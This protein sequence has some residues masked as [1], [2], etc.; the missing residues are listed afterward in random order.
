MNKLLIYSTIFAALGLTA[1][2]ADEDLP[3]QGGTY[4]VHVSVNVDR[5]DVSTDSR[6]IMTE[7]DR[8]GLG[9]GWSASDQLVVTD[10]DGNKV[11]VLSANGIKD[12]DSYGT[13][14]GDLLLWNE[15][16]QTLNF[17][18]L[19]TEGDV[20]AP[21]T[22]PIN[23]SLAEQDGKNEFG[24][25][26]VMTGSIDVNVIG[27][28]LPSFSFAMKHQ[29]TFA[30]F[31]LEMPAGVTLNGE[32]ITIS[33]ANVSNA[34]N[35]NPAT[36]VATG[37]NGDIT[38]KGTNG[39]FYLTMVPGENVELSFAVTVADK[40]Y[41]GTLPAA[42]IKRGSYLNRQGAGIPVKMSAENT[43]VELDGTIFGYNWASANLRSYMACS[44]TDVNYMATFSY[45]PGVSLDDQG[46]GDLKYVPS[47]LTDPNYNATAY[48]FQWNRHFGFPA[49]QQR[50][51]QYYFDVPGAN[52]L[53]S[54]IQDRDWYLYYDM[55]QQQTDYENA[56]YNYQVFLWPSASD[57]CSDGTSYTQWS[58]D[59]SMIGNWKIA[60]SNAFATLVPGEKGET[61]TYPSTGFTG[62]SD[63]VEITLYPFTGVNCEDGSSVVWSVAKS[64]EKNYLD[65]RRL[66][67]QY[68]AVSDIPAA[69][70]FAEDIVNVMLPA[71]GSQTGTGIQYW[72]QYGY[73]WATDCGDQAGRAVCFYF[74]LLDNNRIQIGMGQMPR[75][76]GM[77]VRCIHR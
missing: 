40:K 68:A 13:F 66:P 46:M 73:Y 65:V 57:W 44:P 52:N 23:V 15:G 69:D 43:D 75:K 72:Q 6:T 39:D 28:D 63:D 67:R 49:T 9:F 77:S 54:N 8:N 17:I 56:Q 16:Q 33:G 20:T 18:Y 37:V 29:V 21:V 51:D 24:R 2:G 38:V 48:M 35:V 32:D 10:N 47:S 45:I 36:V 60:D 4:K 11:G 42:T 26:D 31:A 55:V 58:T 70:L 27:G 22:N 25:K 3:Q 12:G 1:C 30:H 41:T 53:P 34:L 61:Y 7:N 14:E 19:G 64:A 76:Y 59:Q 50:Y 62:Q 74:Y 5:D 71:D